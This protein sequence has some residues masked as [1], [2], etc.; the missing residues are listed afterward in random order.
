MEL[1]NAVFKSG[2]VKH[3]AQF[4]QTLEEISDHIQV[5]YNDDVAKMIREVERPML[6][7]PQQPT[8]QIVMDSNGNPIQERFNEMEMY[9]WKKDYELIHNQRAEF[10][11]KEKRVFPIILEQCSQLE[12]AKSLQDTCE[13]SYFMELLKT[14]HSFGANMT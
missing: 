11:E 7:F 2:S 6:K 1:E 9:M 13:K 5:R 3:A 4:T 10:E 8:A 12:G 14:I